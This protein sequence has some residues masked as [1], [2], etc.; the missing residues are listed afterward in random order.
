MKRCNFLLFSLFPLLSSAA[1]PYE[2]EPLIPDNLLRDGA[3][4]FDA[5]A[6][7]QAPLFPWTTTRRTQL[8]FKLPWI[9]MAPR[10]ADL[11]IQVA[12]VKLPMNSTK[13]SRQP[14]HYHQ[15]IA[16]TKQ[17][18]STTLVKPAS[19]P[20]VLAKRP[21]RKLPKNAGTMDR[22]RHDVLVQTDKLL[23]QARVQTHKL[24]QQMREISQAKQ[25]SSRALVT[26][27]PRSRRN[28][29]VPAPV[30]ILLSV[31]PLSCLRF[32]TSSYDFATALAQATIC[33]LRFLAPLVAARR[34]LNYLEEIGMDWYRGRYLR[35]TIHQVHHDYHTTYQVPAA[36]RSLGRLLAQIVS[37]F[38][39]GRFMEYV[40]VGLDQNHCYPKA[41][42]ATGVGSG[43][44]SWLCCFWWMIA[45]MGLGH[46]GA[47]AMSVW[48]G[49]LRVQTALQRPLARQIFTK[50]WKLL[51]WMRDPD[52]WLREIASSQRRDTLKPFHP[53]R[54]L[55]PATWQPLYFLQLVAV[56]NAMTGEAQ[57]RHE[58]M[59][60]LLLQQAFGDEWFRMLMVEKRVALG[61]AL[62]VGYY[63]A[64]FKIFSSIA[65]VSSLGT[66]LTVP[67]VVSVII[68]GWMN[69]SIYFE[70][71]KRDKREEV[72]V[73]AMDQPFG[74]LIW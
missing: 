1:T 31:D 40:V 16:E 56:A 73:V 4:V 49:P 22:L 21:K 74:A 19:K 52:R 42:L 18:Q 51:N 59:R 66:C 48:G 44:C 60:Y 37:L 64:T 67:Y 43:Q 29:D 9:D 12:G 30:A 26:A 3:S 34:G 58:L 62:V 11:N 55:F 57:L 25:S 2:V 41:T 33:T 32:L 50:P 6:S 17:Q 8:P 61:I 24:K 53:N 28:P 38:L 7:S 72:A 14:R 13:S 35:T 47:T 54:L 46:A 36:L 45:T 68:S 70:R 20:L 23:D 71:R 27:P 5:A 10:Q 15:A 63:L 69:V 39:L 65:T